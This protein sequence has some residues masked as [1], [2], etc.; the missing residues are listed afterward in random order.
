MRESVRSRSRRVTGYG[1]RV[2]SPSEPTR[3][4]DWHGHS[5]LARR[6][7]ALVLTA[8]FRS[9]V[10]PLT[11]LLAI[12][13]SLG[14]VVAAALLAGRSLSPLTLVAGGFVGL[15]VV[16]QSVQLLAAARARRAHDLNDRVSLIEA[17][18]G[19]LR[20]TLISGVAMVAAV[21]PVT[22]SGGEAAGVQRPLGIA[23]VGGIL[24]S[25]VVTLLVVPALYAAFEDGASV[26]T[27]RLRTRLP[28]SERRIRT[29]PRVDDEGVVR[30]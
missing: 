4:G 14:G 21:L 23:L 20:P 6:L 29:L 5:V 27:A 26:L 10:E 19:R 11:V 8:R 1:I 22:L 25:L 28:H 9:L 30:S 13:L 18:R 24:M 15:V 12:L 7:L 3:R 16:R 17:G 2:R